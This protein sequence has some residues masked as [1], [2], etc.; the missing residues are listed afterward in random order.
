MLTSFSRTY[1]NA[2]T[3]PLLRLPAEIRNMIFEYAMYQGT[4]DFVWN[5]DSR[6]GIVDPEN[7]YVTPLPSLLFV[8]RQI[9][10]EVA[11]LPYKLNIFSFRLYNLLDLS[12]FLDQRTQE[13]LDLMTEVR[14][15]SH[16]AGRSPW[17]VSAAG[18]R[19]C[20]QKKDLWSRANYGA[21]YF[22]R[23]EELISSLQQADTTVS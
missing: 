19:E 18:W 5:H 10:S 4:I 16:S 17:V 8:S 12:N 11:I 14:C 23:L 9:H 13:Q 21:V 22:W 7:N 20:F 2:T 6:R 3:S 15:Q 1:L